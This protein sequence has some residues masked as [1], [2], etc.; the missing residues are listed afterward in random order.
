MSAYVAATR[1][2]E[3]LPQWSYHSAAWLTA[4]KMKKVAYFG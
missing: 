1:A 2:D 4:D 3:S